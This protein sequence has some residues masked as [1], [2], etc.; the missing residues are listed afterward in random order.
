MRLCLWC[1][2]GRWAGKQTATPL[3]NAPVATPP[4]LPLWDDSRLTD[5][6]E[7]A[8]ISHNWDKLRR[9]IWDHVGFNWYLTPITPNYPGILFSPN[10]SNSPLTQ[11]SKAGNEVC[12]TFQTV[13]ALM[14]A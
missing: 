14:V 13:W 3:A 5:A 6:D 11:T 2:S 7:M 12:A 8:V 1:S 10:P 4:A 9:F